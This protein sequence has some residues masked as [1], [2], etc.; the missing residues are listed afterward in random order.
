MNRHRQL[1][2]HSSSSSSSSSMLHHPRDH[3]RLHRSS[4]IRRPLRRRIW[5]RV[6]MIHSTSTSARRP[7]RRNI[8]PPGHR[9][10]LLRPK[11]LSSRDRPLPQPLGPP[12]AR[13]AHPRHG[14]SVPGRRGGVQRKGLLPPEPSPAVATTGWLRAMLLEMVAPPGLRTVHSRTVPA[15]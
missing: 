12:M 15:A 13:L 2:R 9:R 10:L 6:N 4:N 1:R 7:H 5:D 8:T 3:I 11:R 14:I